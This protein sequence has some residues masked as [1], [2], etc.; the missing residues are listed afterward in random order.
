MHLDGACFAIV[1]NPE[2][3]GSFGEWESMSNDCINKVRKTPKDFNG[4]EKIMV[5]MVVSI[6]DGRDHGDLLHHQ[7]VIQSDW[8]PEH[9]ELEEGATRAGG[10]HARIERLLGTHGVEGDVVVAPGL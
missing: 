3:F 9:A 7:G 10:L 5:F 2:G 6:K 1:S 8:T 4:L